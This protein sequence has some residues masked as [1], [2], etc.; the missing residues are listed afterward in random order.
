MLNNSPWLWNGRKTAAGMTARTS[1]GQRILQGKRAKGQSNPSEKYIF[2]QKVAAILWPVFRGVA[3][4]IVDNFQNIPTGSTPAAEW[5]KINYFTG[6]SGVA[7]GNPS[8][9]PGGLIFAKGTMSQT[10]Y[11]SLVADASA[12]SITFNWN[13]TPSDSS[14]EAT[15]LLGFVIYTPNGNSGGPKMMSGR[16]GVRSDGTIT[17]TGIPAGWFA[18][19]DA[20]YVYPTFRGATGEANEGMISQ[21][22]ELDTV[23]VA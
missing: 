13:A 5:Y 4:F 8:L 7:P 21:T 22:A 10:A 1:R 9:A 17:Y 16:S 19:G 15:D 6:I 20:V 11:N 14:Q 23:V 18:A 2:S 3:G 12:H